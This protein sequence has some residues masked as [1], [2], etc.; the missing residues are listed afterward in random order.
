[1]SD[2]TTTQDMFLG[3]LIMMEKVWQRPHYLLPTR[4]FGTGW[5]HVTRQKA[6]AELCQLVSASAP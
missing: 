6:D 1:M 2:N 5:N 4:A 3:L